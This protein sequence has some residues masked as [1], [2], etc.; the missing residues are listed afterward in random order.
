MVLPC[1]GRNLQPKAW[2]VQSS[3]TELVF[4]KETSK[5]RS[6]SQGIRADVTSRGPF[7]LNHYMILRFSQISVNGCSL[8]D[9]VMYLNTKTLLWGKAPPFCWS[10]TFSQAPTQAGQGFSEVVTSREWPVSLHL[11]RS[12]LDLKT[13]SPQE[14][15]PQLLSSFLYLEKGLKLPYAVLV[16]FISPSN[17]L[18]Y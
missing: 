7:H 11:S 18:K 8:R 15:P 10:L 5:W 1:L 4:G 17:L 9:P 16:G 6:F 2:L 13:L 14:F 3:L 12:K